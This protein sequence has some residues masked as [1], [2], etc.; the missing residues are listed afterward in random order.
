MPANDKLT[1]LISERQLDLFLNI[2]PMLG[3]LIAEDFIA[4]AG[5]MQMYLASNENT[6]YHLAMF[7]STVTAEIFPWWLHPA[8]YR[9]EINRLCYLLISFR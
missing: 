4:K 1:E 8:F 6:G 7:I 5:E 3:K 9:N 2:K